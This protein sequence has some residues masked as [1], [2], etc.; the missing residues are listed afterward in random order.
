MFVTI[1]QVNA[2]RILMLFDKKVV[3]FIRTDA[4]HFLSPGIPDKTGKASKRLLLHSEQLVI[5]QRFIS[6]TS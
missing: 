3:Y 2:D 4:R 6:G 5:D 1:L